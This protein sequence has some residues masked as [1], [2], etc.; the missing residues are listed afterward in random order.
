MNA[1][2]KPP[3]VIDEKLSINS[4]RRNLTFCVNVI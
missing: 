4:S 3:Y 1:K 2:V